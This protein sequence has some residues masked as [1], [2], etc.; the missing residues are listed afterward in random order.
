MSK[1]RKIDLLVIHCSDTAGGDAASI[2]KY[3]IEKNGWMDIGYHYVIL[4]NGKI[5]PGRPESDI[6]AHCRGFNVTSLG[7]CLVGNNSA[8]ES[9]ADDFTDQ[10][11][12]S[13]VRLIRHLQIKHRIPLDGIKCHYELD[14]WDKTCPNMPGFLV[15]KLVKGINGN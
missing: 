11:L 15:R 7:I 10:Q 3:H 6:G 5:E 1:E 8:Y 12:D 2:R 9:T 13:M 14:A 4:R